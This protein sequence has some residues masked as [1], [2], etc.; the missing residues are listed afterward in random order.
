MA[1]RGEKLGLQPRQLF[2]VAAV[3]LQLR[4][5]A[6][7]EDADDD[8]QEGFEDRR[9]RVARGGVD[10]GHQHEVRDRER[11]ADRE[12]DAR[13]VE[14]EK[15]QRQ[16]YQRKRAH[17]AEVELDL[18]CEC[19]GETSDRGDRVQVARDSLPWKDD[20]RAAEDRDHHR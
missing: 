19:N 14:R 12:L 2:Q 1:E 11:G 3:L 15:D 13:E 6:P 18:E 17:D 16:E 20:E 7:H 4:D 10:E 9:R 8:Q 5:D